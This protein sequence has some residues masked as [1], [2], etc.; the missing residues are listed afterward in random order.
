MEDY[1]IS[2]NKCSLSCMNQKRPYENLEG[3]KCLETCDINTE[4]ISQSNKKCRCSLLFF[5]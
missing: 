5:E 4:P 2:S 3:T 1:A